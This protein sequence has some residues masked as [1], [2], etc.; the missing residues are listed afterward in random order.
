MMGETK[1]YS[2]TL[3][4]GQTRLC[5]DAWAK[6]FIQV[7]GGV[8][9]CCYNTPVGNINQ[10]TLDEVLNSD[11]AMGYRQGLLTGDLRPMC[12]ICGDK[13][14]VPLRE[15]RNAVEEWYATGKMSLH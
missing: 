3:G 12:R 1:I 5:L 10:G 13:R 8:R 9:L 11:V 7:D 4:P 2:G 14:I 15:L 6:A